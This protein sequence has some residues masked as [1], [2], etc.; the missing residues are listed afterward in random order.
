M[1]PGYGFLSE[2]VEFADTISSAGI[3]FVGPSPASINAMGLKHE[4]RSIALDAN[5]PIIPGTG[6]LKSAHDAKEAATRLGL[7]IML[8]ATGGCGGMGLQICYSEQ[9]VEKAFAMVESR[10]G[11]LFKN[12]G[13]F[14][15][16]YYPSSRH[17]EV[18]VAGNGEIVVAFG[19]RECSLQRRHQKVIEECPSP[20]VERH[21]GLRE[22]ML[23][24][25]VNYASQL[26]YK[27]VG[28]VE[29]LVDDETAD[30]FFLEMNTRL[31][32]EHGITEL[33]YGVDLVHLMLRQA[34]Y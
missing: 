12:S 10:A 28:T 17:V 3:T 30:F 21:P 27:S 29:F 24:A 1:I 6:L 13:V 23:S 26:K 14:L 19:E 16:K 5:V 31:Q 20:F 7:P 4:A 34:D 18:Q 33:C 9:E 22:K 32:V 25:A 15:E 11:T 8:K 2:N